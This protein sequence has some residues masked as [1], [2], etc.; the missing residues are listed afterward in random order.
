MDGLARGGGASRVDV[1]DDW[2]QGR[3]AHGGLTAGLCTEAAI[4]AGA[5]LPPLRSA[6]FALMGPASGALGVIPTTLRAGRSAVFA[7]VDVAGDAGPAARALLCF[8]AGRESA[9]HYGDLPAP[10]APPP[11]ACEPYFLPGRSPGFAQ[12]FDSRLAGGARPMTPGARPEVRVWVRHRD[13]AARASIAGLVALA[14]AVPPPAFIL[15]TAPAPFSTA[16][17]ALDVLTGTPT[18]PDGWWLIDARAETAAG[19]YSSQAMTVWSSDG[20]PAMAC[21][22][23]VAVFA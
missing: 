5:D 2:R 17:W 14:D 4:R 9:L 23:T 20:T 10:D 18:S 8:G 16:T 12:H 21:R 6:H 3:T 13:E 7:G 22:Q 19:G 15:F 11:D 1:T